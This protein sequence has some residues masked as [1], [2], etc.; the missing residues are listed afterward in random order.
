MHKKII[1]TSDTCGGALRFDG[2][3]ISIKI[4]ATYLSFG[5]TPEE[6]IEDYPTLT[7][8]DIEYCKKY[9]VLLN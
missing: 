8:E 9:L 1:S 7:L 2:T 3:R 5:M 4:V 6:I